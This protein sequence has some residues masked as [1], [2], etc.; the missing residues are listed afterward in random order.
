MAVPDVLDK[1]AVVT[2]LNDIT[3]VVR[4]VPDALLDVCL[5]S[6]APDTWSEAGRDRSVVYHDDV[7]P[8]STQDIFPNTFQ[9]VEQAKRE[10]ES[11]VDSLP[12]LV[13]LVD[14]QGCVMRANRI[15]ETWNL[16]R[17]ERVKGRYLHDLLHRACSDRHCYLELF[18][19]QVTDRVMQG[20]SIRHEAYDQVLRRYLQI[21]S[22]PVFDRDHQPTDTAVVVVRDITDLK[23]TEQERENLIEDLAAFAHTVAHDLKNPIG[24]VIGYST[25]IE[26]DLGVMPEQELRQCLQAIARFS[27]KTNN[28]IE[29][30]LLLAEVRSSAVQLA[31]LD[32]ASI[33]AEARQRLEHMI[34]QHQAKIIVPDSWP[35]VIGYA[36]WIEE[37]WTNYISNAL[38]YGG[39]PACVEL[40]SDRQPDGMVRFWVRDN[41]NG[42]APDMQAR[43]FTPFTR[44]API[45]ATGNGL[46]LSIVRRIIEKIGGRIGVES[47]H[48]PE[49]GCTFYFTLKAAD[50]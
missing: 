15:V 20:D 12:D 44:L 47:S 32:M 4:D 25:L 27:H 8:D 23:R 19:R 24:L 50:V 7:E 48:I 21:S 2:L 37:V 17:V 41:G 18:V 6:P 46:G 40:G 1:K 10:W 34:Q 35:T 3:L 5:M 30:L 33:V 13:A 42:L 11:T 16:D 43:L 29:E 38:K 26:Q 28:I 14:H 31:P 22:Q 9:R 39:Q 49:Q 36:P 45:R